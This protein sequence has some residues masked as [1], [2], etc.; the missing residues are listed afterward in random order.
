MSQYD[1]DLQKTLSKML[2]KNDFRIVDPN[3]YFQRIEK[4]FPISNNGIEWSLVQNRLFEAV[5]LNNRNHEVSKF[6]NEVLLNY[7]DLKK[8][9][10]TV[11]GDDLTEFGY[12]LSFKH[13]INCFEKFLEVPQHI[14][15]IFND[16][17][18][19]M[20]YTFEDDIYF[21]MPTIYD[22]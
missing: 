6:I 8:E 4:Y 14:Y 2:D 22:N 11:I 13:F 9:T 15:V 5:K 3:P 19:C 12:E 17:N 10:V 18:A 21:G 7:P 16:S 1:D 20:N